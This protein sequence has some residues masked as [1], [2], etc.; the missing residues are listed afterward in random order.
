MFPTAPKMVTAAT[1]GGWAAATQLGP[2]FNVVNVVATAGDSVKLPPASSPTMCWVANSGVKSMQVFASQQASGIY[3]TVNGVSGAVGIPQLAGSID[4]YI[5]V[6]PGVWMV[7]SGL[8]FSG[9]FP[10]MSSQDGIVAHAG[11]GQALGTPLSA[12]INRVVTVATAADSVQLP[13]SA[14]G[15]QI[16]VAN[17]AAANSMNVFPATGDAINALAANAA[18]ACAAGKTVEFY[19][20]ASGFWHGVLSA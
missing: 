13:P 4:A 7:E 3:D 9:G 18:F 19:C 6:Q 5:S 15:M 12:A 1:G 17:G 2:D 10:T 20:A 14:P 16:I 11:G 8:G